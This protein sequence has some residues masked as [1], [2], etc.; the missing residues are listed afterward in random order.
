M[1]NEIWM[2][3]P[4]YEG[5]YEA[6]NQGQIRSLDRHGVLGKGMGTRKGRILRQCNRQD[7]QVVGLCK[8]GILKQFTVHRLVMLAFEGERPIGLEICHG[9]GDPRNNAKSN[10][11]YDTKFANAA[12]KV[13]HGTGNLA[14]T[15]P[16]AQ[17]TDEEVLEIYNRC[18]SGEPQLDIANDL[19]VSKVTINHIATGRSWNSVTNAKWKRRHQ[20]ITPV[21]VRRINE[22]QAENKTLDEI[23][24]I[25]GISKPSAFRH[26]K[27][28]SRL[29][30]IE[31]ALSV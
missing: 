17:F 13:K 1:D 15:N 25:L 26:S 10:L 29:S 3:I 18:Q 21:I 11:R 7:Y 8:N 19:G 20:I 24:E 31:G 22:L 12:D 2:P 28:K 5:L 4:G 6:S 14:D 16:R 27:G 30:R 9:D 23:A